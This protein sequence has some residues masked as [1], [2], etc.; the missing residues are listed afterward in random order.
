MGYFLTAPNEP[1]KLLSLEGTL[2]L[3]THFLQ[4]ALKNEDFRSKSRY[5]KKNCRRHIVDILRL[6]F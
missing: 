4:G 1:F 3:V 5:A 2:S 6:K